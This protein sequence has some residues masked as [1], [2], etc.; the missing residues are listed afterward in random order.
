MCIR[1]PEALFLFWLS[2]AVS[3][4]GTS[5]FAEPKTNPVIEDQVGRSFLSRIGAKPLA[6]LATTAE[7]RVVLVNI[8]KGSSKYGQICSE[9]APDAG[10]NIAHQV[11]SALAAA[12]STPE[13]GG[14]LRL[15]FGKQLATAIQALFHRTQ[16]LQLYRDGMY[17]L[18]VMYWNG[19]ISGQQYADEAKTFFVEAKKLIEKE[20]DLTD[21][22]V[23]GA[24]PVALPSLSPLELGEPEL[25]RAA[26]AADRVRANKLITDFRQAK[27]ENS[28]TKMKVALTALHEI[29]VTRNQDKGDKDRTLTETELRQILDRLRPL[30]KDEQGQLSLVTLD[31]LKGKK[32]NEFINLFM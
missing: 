10:E 7:R 13:V 6:T 26:G 8:N 1:P 30:A 31:G 21:G 14:E 20:L 24:L 16:G 3:G 5:L 12:I 2:I 23:G 25:T 22:V 17:N 15:Q 32:P 9:P 28:S 4:C 11:S 19:V 29:L 18:C 27:K